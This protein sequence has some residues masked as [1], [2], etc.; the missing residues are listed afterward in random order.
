[1]TITPDAP[2]PA[3]FSIL[4]KRLR[5]AKTH[6]E[7]TSALDAMTEFLSKQSSVPASAQAPPA[8]LQEPVHFGTKS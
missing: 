4:S 8:Q 5:E 7:F 1:M 3:E 6:Q 2:F